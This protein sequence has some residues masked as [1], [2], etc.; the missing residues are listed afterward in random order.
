MK[1]RWLPQ[2]R[3]PLFP[4]PRAARGQ[5]LLLLLSFFQLQNAAWAA[6]SSTPTPSRSPPTVYSVN[7][8]GKLA[9][10]TADPDSWAVSVDG[11]DRA[12]QLPGQ[13][14]DSDSG[15]AIGPGNYVA[16]RCILAG[17]LS[18]KCTAVTG[19]R[20]IAT[21]APTPSSDVRL[22]ILVMAI[23][24]NATSVCNALPAMST[25]EV[26]ELYLGSDGFADYLNNC[27]YGK[28][29]V[30]RSIFKVVPVTVP[31]SSAIMSCDPDA[32][33][34]AAR[35]ALPTGNQVTSY[36]HLTYILPLG[37]T[38]CGWAG[39][40]ELPGFQS[41]LQPTADGEVKRNTVM[42]ELLQ[43]FGL[44]PAWRN[45]VQYGDNSTVMGSGNS[46]PSAPE[47]SRLGWASPAAVLNSSSLPASTFS[48]FALRA[49][50][51]GSK[52]VMVKITPDWLGAAYTKNIYL[53]LRSRGG[54]DDSLPAQF[55][56]KV[57]I[58]EAGT[59]IDSSGVMSYMDPIVS[60]IGVV[61]PNSA[62]TLPGYNLQIVTGDIRNTG[63][64][65]LVKVCRYV[66]GPNEC[67]EPEPAQ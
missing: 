39:L 62:F 63:R 48:S 40:G 65:I 47:L 27:S 9:V 35:R 19:V 67:I 31:C 57:S 17:P 60:L 21:P 12:Y 34:S 51:L 11:I 7:L 23:R 49:T 36:S 5:T 3:Q 45:G 58:H 16:L 46:C 66:D 20:I 41:W 26:E 54:G 6:W 59:S 13:P 37:I 18:T 30:D 43:N 2:P 32:I 53:A 22:N 42:Q 14:A 8:S 38:S 10:R 56:R 1:S 55:S 50:Y 15:A 61:N 29:V 24:L 44:H 33:A 25:A 64:N 52:G 28:M 4:S